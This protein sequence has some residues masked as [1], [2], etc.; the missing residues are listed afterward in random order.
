MMCGLFSLRGLRITATSVPVAASMVMASAG[1]YAQE[2]VSGGGSGRAVSIVPR[3][4]ITETLTDNVRLSS[5]N[6]QSDM[7]TE[8]SPGIHISR[9]SRR[10]K[11]FFDYSLSGINYAQNSSSSR[12]Q[13]ALNTAGTLEAVDNWAYLD[14]SGSISQQAISAFGA[15]PSGNTSSI[16]SNQTEVS[17]YRLSPYVRGRLGDLA[18]YEAR[19][20]R[21]DTNSRSGLGSGVTSTDGLVNINGDT[22]FRRLGW[23]ANATRQSTD[24]NF[25]RS[26]EADRFI[27]GLSYTVTP[28][29]IVSAR[30][31]RE[32]NNYTSLDK[33]S[34]ANS[35]VG[36]N[37]NP[38]QTTRFAASVDHRSFGNAHSLNFEHRTARTAW[39][40]SDTKDVSAT[41][42]QAVV[43]SLGSIFDLYYK[44]FASIE[45]DPVRRAQLVNAYLLANGINPNAVV[46]SSF[47][48]SALSL[49]RR[50]D[51]SFALL[52]VRDT[53]TFIATR[54]ESTRLDTVSTAVDDFS[55]S[56]LVRQR[57]F[58]VNYTHR[59]TPDYSMGVLVSQQ[60]TSGVSSLQDATLRFLNV[61]LTGKVGNRATASVGVRRVVSSGNSPYVENAIT[62]TL[63]VLF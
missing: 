4:S 32:A 6:R 26:T 31:G 38:S 5:A 22:S 35:G 7:I 33:Q 54:S 14:F 39:R 23:S 19:Y 17:S 41:P 16:N 3:V 30:G 59:L 15:Q 25:G 60:R 40:F 56:A 1:T 63:N 62:G 29:L 12:I 36:F 10:L 8:V 45:S 28:Q 48:T 61:S 58:S 9:E 47:L 46:V 43:G 55:T 57:G 34:Y 18:N 53:I 13:H 42:N 24:Y 49:Q 50:Q 27:V 52:G 2:S 44:Q 37:W 20:S 51:L 11:G 21:S